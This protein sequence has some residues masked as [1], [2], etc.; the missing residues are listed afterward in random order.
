MNHTEFDSLYTTTATG[1][2]L[3]EQNRQRNYMALIFGGPISDNDIFKGAYDQSLRDAADAGF[4]EQQFVL[5]DTT[6]AGTQEVFGDI[7]KRANGGISD[8]QRFLGSR[9]NAPGM[10]VVTY[11]GK[12]DGRH[13]NII[14]RVENPWGGGEHGM[15]QSSRTNAPLSDGG[16]VPLF[17]G[18]EGGV[19]GPV[20]A[21]VPVA[22]IAPDA[23][24]DMGIYYG[25]EVGN[26]VS[27]FQTEDRGNLQALFIR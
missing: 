23:I 14:G 15:I 5:P 25:S 16:K 26:Y 10:S 18:D 27:N 11:N 4:R 24:A 8:V 1:L 13:H 22:T 6:L 9:G 7:R 19:Y 12:R 21:N 2:M 20:G 17:Y 3:D